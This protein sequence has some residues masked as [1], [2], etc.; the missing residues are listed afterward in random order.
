MTIHDNRII[1]GDCTQVLPQL[2]AESA[3]F[4]LTDPPYLVSYRERT[5]RSIPGD[6]SDT[7]LRPTFME[8]YRV[9][10][11]DSFAVS[12]YG[13]PHADRFQTA[14]KSAGFRICGQFVFPKPYVSSVKYLKCQHESAF[15]LVKGRPP[16]PKKPISDV[17]PWPVN[18]GNKL[19]PTQK[20]LGILKP[21]IEA[22][23]NPGE[24]VLDPFAGSGSTLLAA[25]QLGRKFL[26]IEL[27]AGYHAIAQER[28]RSCQTVAV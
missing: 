2:P 7:W 14:Y 10:K 26:G 17:V 24:L 4:V 5:G 18:T 25:Q 3:D 23:T 1:H 21:L 20:P 28:L 13:W 16:F 22:F 9:L 6:G 12:F 15:L 19:H 27:G 8:L 11:P